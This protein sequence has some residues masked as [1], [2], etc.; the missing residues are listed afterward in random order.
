MGLR[1]NTNVS[2]LQAQNSL[3]KT[4]KATGETLAKLSSGE[5]ITKAADD[6]AGLAISEKLKSNIRGIRQA[7]RNSNDGISLIQTA[8]GGLNE[9]GNI[10]IRLRELAVQSASDTVGEEERQFTDMEFQNLKDEIQRISQVTKFNGKDL[11]TGSGDDVDIQVGIN[12]DEFEDRIVY[13]RDDLDAT[14]STLGVDGLTSST[15]EG[16]RESLEALDSAIVRVSENRARLGALQNRLQSTVRNLR[17]ADE[18]LS[19]ANSRIRDADMA[20]Q[21][22]ELVKNQ[23]LN[24]SG[25]SVLSNANTKSQ[26]ALKL[27]G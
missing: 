6:A 21:S 4:N 16:A 24:Q 14:I 3:H 11:L 18:N 17:I 20:K 1:I 8:E 12:N 5:R 13:K 10:L 27:I 7:T 26:N 23:I 15:K 22:S 9:V 19:A 25:V 2:A